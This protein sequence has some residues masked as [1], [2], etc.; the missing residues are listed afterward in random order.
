[1]LTV[2]IPESYP[3]HTHPE[4]SVYADWITEDQ[5]VRATAHLIDMYQQELLGCCVLFS[6]TEW[7][8][9]NV[10]PPPAINPN[11]ST[12]DSSS[13]NN[14]RYSDNNDWVSGEFFVDR[15]SKF[16][17]HVIPV[18]SREAVSAAME[19]L[20]SNRKIA[21]ATHNISAYR[22]KAKGG[23]DGFVKDCDD[24]GETAAGGRLLHLLDLIKAEG[25]LVVVTRWYG[26]V[27]LGP[28]RF[29]HI[30]NVAR[31]ILEARGFVRS[32]GQAGRKNT[33]KK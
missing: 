19:R 1:M 22:F 13:E 26:G 23:S 9:E 4:F 20:L 30:N 12:R 27:H 29:R 25:V 21:R 5:Q 7:L 33:K 10:I 24:D 11:T 8:K 31:K 18:D 17:G 16:Q 15:K 14:L 3:S 32:T 2:H 28:D 6:W